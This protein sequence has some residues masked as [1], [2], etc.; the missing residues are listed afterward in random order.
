MGARVSDSSVEAQVL[1]LLAGL[2][3]PGPAWDA[4]HPLGGQLCCGLFLE[5]WHRECHL[6]PTVLT[7][8]LARH[9]TL[10]LDIYYQPGNPM[11]ESGE[12]EE[13]GP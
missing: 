9:L 12:E 13:T 6:S 7:A 8:A 11:S 1:E 5:V 3:P 10:R 2:P 4:L